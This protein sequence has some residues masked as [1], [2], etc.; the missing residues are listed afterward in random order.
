MQ[1]KAS[2][3][4]VF[5]GCTLKYNHIDSWKEVRRIYKLLLLLNKQGYPYVFISKF[6]VNKQSVKF[7]TISLQFL[8]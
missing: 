6:N 5:K 4:N 3:G 1:K 7:E 2:V 8:F